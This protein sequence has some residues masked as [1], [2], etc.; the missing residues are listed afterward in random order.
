VFGFSAA[1]TVGDL[2]NDAK[3]DIII[4]DGDSANRKVTVLRNSGNFNLSPLAIDA[5]T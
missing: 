3:V 1:V 5:S 4:V 2:N